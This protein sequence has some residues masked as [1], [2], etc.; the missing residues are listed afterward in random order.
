MLPTVG[1]PVVGTGEGEIVG[2]EA[3]GDLVG[4]EVGIGVGTEVVGV[5]D[6]IMVLG[7]RLGAV[8]GIEL[9]GDPVGER[10]SAIRTTKP[11]LPWPFPHPCG[12]TD[13]AT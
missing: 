8:V 5:A 2:A 11:F 12:G 10:V 3:M 1:L 13:N 6:G 7:L 9:A 4:V